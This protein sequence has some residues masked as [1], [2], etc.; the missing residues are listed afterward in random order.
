MQT[1]LKFGIFKKKIAFTSSKP[2]Y[3]DVEPPSF[4]VASALT[5]WITAMKDE[6]S[7]LHRQGTWT[8]VPLAPSQNIVG[9]K[10]TYKVKWNADRSVSRYK[11]RL[12]AKGFHQQASLDYDETFS[13]IIKPTIVRIILT[14]AA[15]FDWPLCQLDISNAFL[16]GYLKEDVFIAQPLS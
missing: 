3:L 1:R 6:F 2:D 8:F 5:P 10:W 16:H 4:S 11:A 15:H 14:L 7:A 9:C 13:P 12:V